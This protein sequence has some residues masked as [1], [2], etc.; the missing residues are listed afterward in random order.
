V[1]RRVIEPDAV[2]LEI[3]ARVANPSAFARALAVEPNVGSAAVGPSAL[4]QPEPSAMTAAMIETRG[5]GLH[6]LRRADLDAA[7]IN[8][9]GIDLRRSS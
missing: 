1:A 5:S 8:V 6:A 9:S 3:G 7:G 4:P 2:D